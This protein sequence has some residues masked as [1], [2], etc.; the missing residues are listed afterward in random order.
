MRS[1]LIDFIYKLPFQ[2]LAFV[3]ITFYLIS[4]VGFYLLSGNEYLNSIISKNLISSFIGIF[5]GSLY[6]FNKKFFKLNYIYIRR[7]LEKNQNKIKFL[8]YYLFIIWIFNFI[9][10][11]SFGSFYST[12][13]FQSINVP[14]LHWL[15]HFSLIFQ[16]FLLLLI[17]IKKPLD[18]FKNKCWLLFNFQ[19]FLSYFTIST[20]K[21]I[22]LNYFLI[23]ILSISVYTNSFTILNIKSFTFFLKRLFLK[24]RL[25]KIIARTNIIFVILIIVSIA[26][27]IQRSN[28]TS[29]LSRLTFGQDQ[30]LLLSSA[31]NSNLIQ[32]SDNYETL[33]QPIFFLYWFKSFLRPLFPFLY[34]IHDNYSEFLIDITKGRLT[35]DWSQTGHAPNNNIFTDFFL[36]DPDNSYIQ[37]LFSLIYS[38]LISFSLVRCLI[39]FLSNPWFKSL[40]SYISF[41][42]LGILYSNPLLPW[43]DSQAFFMFLICSTVLIL[44]V[45]TVY[46]KLT[47]DKIDI[48]V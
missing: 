29:I 40:S 44:I 8:F 23:I 7:E 17:I 3:N 27:L 45:F 46:S 38:F 37:N 25:N 48:K 47:Y 30:L 18:I 32:S 12:T 6:Y 5:L 19:T 20:S 4:F 10:N 15:K 28:I 43:Q 36:F 31:L 33:N 14:L 41:S 35:L 11:S 26:F 13:R 21:A 34:N 2:S 24:A 42:Y 1:L 39:N 22:L 16:P 9:L